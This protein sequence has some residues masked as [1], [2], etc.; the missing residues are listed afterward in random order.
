VIV[1]KTGEIIETA[2]VTNFFDGPA[3]SYSKSLLAAAGELE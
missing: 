1:M 3:H 2:Q